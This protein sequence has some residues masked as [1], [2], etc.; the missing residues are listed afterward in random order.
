MNENVRDDINNIYYDILKELYSK[1]NLK[2][3][4]KEVPFITFTL[5]DLDKNFLFF[6]FAQRNWPW[7]L[8]ECSDRLFQLA[9]PG[10]ASWYSKNWENRKEDGGLYSY[11]YTDRLNGQMQK[12]LDNVSHVEDRQ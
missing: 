1:G 8:R 3:K 10:I 9:N 2:G 4:R 12:H 7:I 11:H 5:T 6:P